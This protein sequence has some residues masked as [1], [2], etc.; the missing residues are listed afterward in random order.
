M[1]EVMMDMYV[2]V[3]EN[4]EAA[5]DYINEQESRM[6]SAGAGNAYFEQDYAEN[7]NRFKAEAAKLYGVTYRYIWEE[8]ANG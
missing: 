3:G 5:A 8:A 2:I 6:I 1:K 7:I 4:A